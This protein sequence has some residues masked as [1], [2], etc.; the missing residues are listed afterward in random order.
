M[1]E[2]A[3]DWIAGGG[4]MGAAVRSLDWSKTSLGPLQTWPQ[5]L[6]T[7]VSTCLSS[8]FPIL[9]LVVEVPRS[10]L[11]V[12]AD[13]LR[14]AQVISN[15]LTNAAK[16]TEPGGRLVVSAQAREGNVELWIA[17]NGIGIS[18]EMLPHVFELFTQERQAIDRARGGLGLGLAI[19]KNLMTMHSGSVTAS[20][21]GRDAGST[22]TIRLPTAMGDGAQPDDRSSASQLSVTTA[23][24]LRVLIVDDN[25]DAAEMLEKAMIELG[26]ETRIGYDGASA[27]R[28]VE[29]FEPQ[30]AI[31]DIGLPLMD[32]YEL[33]GRLRQRAGA[34][35]KFR[36]VALTGYGQKGDIGRALQADFDEHLV[37]PID[38]SKLG[39]LLARSVTK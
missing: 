36:R 11:V 26:C 35:G 9:I 4:E 30:L 12:D 25:A 24:A 34:G 17:D 2:E 1:I 15:L 37:K 22:F 5:S 21:K 29:S 20:S 13:P 28:I 7:I 18:E 10:G 27:L 19:V 6:R 38:L 31:L 39:Q 33:A 8:R 23:S 14:I 16:Y 32:G 3:S